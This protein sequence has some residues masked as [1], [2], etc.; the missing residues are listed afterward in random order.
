MSR[1]RVKKTVSGR[2]AIHV[3]TIDIAVFK[4]HSTTIGSSMIV[5]YK[6]DVSVKVSRPNKHY[7]HMIIIIN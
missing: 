4:S 5:I 7:D 3:M 1:N 6:R 2:I